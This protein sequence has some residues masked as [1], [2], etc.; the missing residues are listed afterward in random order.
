MRMGARGLVPPPPQEAV[1]GRWDTELGLVHSSCAHP[2]LGRNST[3]LLLPE[4]GPESWFFPPHRHRWLSWAA[5]GWVLVV[6]L[7]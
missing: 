2:S 7:L 4:K 3:V 1:R 5:L 6:E